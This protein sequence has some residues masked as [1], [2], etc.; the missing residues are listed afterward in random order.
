MEF[1]NNR[2]KKIRAGKCLL[3]YREVWTG[4]VLQ[5]ATHCMSSLKDVYGP[6]EA[7]M[8][9]DGNQSNRMSKMQDPLALA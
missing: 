5:T 6:R 9:E 8:T 4:F 2:K 7:S 1:C 3:F